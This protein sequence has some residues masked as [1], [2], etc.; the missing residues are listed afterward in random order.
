MVAAV[1][2]PAVPAGATH[3]YRCDIG[4]DRRVR[5][6]ACLP[7]QIWDAITAGRPTSAVCAVEST[8]GVNNI[9]ECSA[10]P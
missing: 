5:E 4:E 10:Q 3:A 8:L 9:K 2:V 6:A 1:G 7:H